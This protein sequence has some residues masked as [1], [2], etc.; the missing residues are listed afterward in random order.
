MQVHQSD[1]SERREGGKG[2]VE[3]TAGNG[4]CGRISAGAGEAGG[5]HGG[6][7][8]EGERV[9]SPSYSATEIRNRW[10]NGRDK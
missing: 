7:G 5:A 9:R 3:L 10:E 1:R 6:V 4:P 2:E 8:C